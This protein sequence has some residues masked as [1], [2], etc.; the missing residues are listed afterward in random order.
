ML[1]LSIMPLD[2]EHIDEVC[3]D[4][5]EQEKKGTYTHAMFIMYFTPNDTPPEEKAKT[6]C[7]VLDMYKEKLDKAGAKYGVLVQSTIGHITA[8]EKQHP[9]QQAI[10]LPNGNVNAPTCCP[11]DANFRQ[12]MKVQMKELAKRKPSIVMIDDDVG[13]LYRS[14]VRGCACPAHLAEFNRRANADMTREELYAHV[15]GDTEE[16][17]RYKQIYIDTFKDS[18]VDFVKIMRE[19]IDE[20]DPTIQGVVSGIYSNFFCE[21]S[22]DTARAFAGK[23]N[24]TI[25]RLNG[26]P[27]S[28]SFKTG[29]A[30]F[31]SKNMFAAAALTETVRDKVDIFLAETDP[32]PHNRYST[33]A[34]LLHAH[35]TGVLLEGAK[36]AKH[37]ITRLCTHEPA[38][39][40]AFRKRLSKYSKFYEKICEYYEELKPF[41]C[42]MPVSVVPDYHLEPPKPTGSTP[43]PWSDCILERF[44]LPLYFGNKKGG[45]VFLD[46]SSAGRFSDKEIKEFFKGTTIL[47]ANAAKNLAERGFVD[48]LGV[49]IKEWDGKIV[50][51]EEIDGVRIPKQ[52]GIKEIVVKKDGVVPLSYNVNGARF[53]KTEKL[54][55]ASTL[56]KNALGGTTVVF[57]GTPDAPFFY[58]TAFSF[59][60]ETRKKQFINILEKLGHLPVYYP[61]DCEMYLRAGRLANDDIFCAVFNLSFDVMDD[62][63]LV[64]NE[65][66]SKI[67]ILDSN[68]ERV[69]CEFTRDGNLYRINVQAG[70]LEPVILFLGR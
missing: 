38:S 55:P 32:C 49:D 58:N 30:R 63:P 9:F 17:K 20:I 3:A 4:V 21:F 69:P 16:D 64:V 68:G 34:T 18:L 66:I 35:F 27:Y 10:G 65:D 33:S 59:L 8:P 47:S 12:Y 29:G 19:G 22:G 57:C 50:S 45:A 7:K 56:Y 36:G 14:S 6:Q 67:E 5:I 42:R 15:I 62:I 40:I 46:D 48:M 1:N 53:T 28:N 43:S 37:W 23:G 41:G 39:G 61:E 11:L 24:P 2:P 13:L 44:G 60:N 25:V 26:G 31:F 70:A 52:C 54:F 51:A